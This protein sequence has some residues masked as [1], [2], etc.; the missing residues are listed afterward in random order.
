LSNVPD[1]L[2]LSEQEFRARSAFGPTQRPNDG[3][4]LPDFPSAP[5]DPRRGIEV[6]PIAAAGIS[7]NR[8][9]LDGAKVADPIT[10]ALGRLSGGSSLKD[11]I[12]ALLHGQGRPRTRL[13]A[14]LPL[15]G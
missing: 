4:R 7:E 1:L 13:K 2:T 11:L 9:S 3:S 12:E 15:L 8:V 6:P 10:A 14:P 5:L